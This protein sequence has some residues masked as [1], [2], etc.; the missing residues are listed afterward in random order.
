MP[1]EYIRSVAQTVSG[2]VENR[3]WARQLAEEARRLRADARRERDRARQLRQ[4]RAPAAR[5][6]GL[7]WPVSAVSR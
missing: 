2:A 4:A 6:G 1:A 5:I 7:A 3:V